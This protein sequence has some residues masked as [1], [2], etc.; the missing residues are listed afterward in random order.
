MAITDVQLT[1]PADGDNVGKPMLAFEF[2][3]QD[4]PYTQVPNRES[5]E[6]VN[7]KDFVNGCLWEGALYTIVGMLKALGEYENSLDSNGDLDVPTEPEFW[8][9]RELFVRRAVNRKQKERFPDIPDY[10][11]QA[12]GYSPFKEDE[13]KPAAKPQSREQS[14]LPG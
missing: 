14:L 12:Q 11:I 4:S 10:W 13:A 5:R 8:L 6:F 2:T 7:R 1:S 9:T 3:V